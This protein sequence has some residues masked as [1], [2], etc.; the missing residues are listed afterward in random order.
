MLY[1]K[2]T[3]LFTFQ[4]MK[5]T[6]ASPLSFTPRTVGECLDSKRTL[7]RRIQNTLTSSTNDSTLVFWKEGQCNLSPAESQAQSVLDRYQSLCEIEELLNAASALKMTDVVMPSFCEGV[8]PV[9]LS[10]GL[11]RDSGVW[12]LPTLKSLMTHFTDQANA[13]KQN[14]MAYDRQIEQILQRDLD[15]NRKEHAEKKIEAHKFTASVPTESVPTDED[16][17]ELQETARNRAKVQMSVLVDPVGVRDLVLRMKAFVTMLETYVDIKIDAINSSDVSEEFVKFQALRT[18]AFEMITEGKSTVVPKETDDHRLVSLAELGIIT[19]TLTSGVNSAIPQLQ[20]VSYCKGTNKKPEHPEVK[21]V[22]ENLFDVFHNISVLLSYRQA[23]REGMGLHFPTLHPLSGVPLSVDGLIRLGF[24]EE[25]GVQPKRAKNPSSGRGGRKGGYSGRGG[26]G[27]YTGHQDQWA[28]CDVE[29]SE[30]TLES[31]ALVDGLSKLF[32]MLDSV[33]KQ[34]SN[35]KKEHEKKVLES[36]ST[37]QESRT[38]NGTALKPGELED[39]AKSV[40]TAEAKTWTVS[41]GV[42]KTLT[43]VKKLLNQTE[44]LQSSVRKSA[45]SMIK[46]SVPLEHEMTWA[47]QCDTLSGWGM[48]S[49]PL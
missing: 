27:G 19:K 6:F 23:Y 39:I 17:A 11:L 10:L 9:R 3:R 7:D 22:K 4:T 20:V 43:R 37:K 32:S 8:E 31:F 35:C 1:I 28:E 44:E 36:I 41:D 30:N 45:N 47:N 5:K 14:S 48:D 2:Q 42:D 38:K 49:A 16:L 21:K 33:D 12:L 29:S 46:V 40:R 15:K 26:R 13:V 24:I 25:K 18:S 34:V